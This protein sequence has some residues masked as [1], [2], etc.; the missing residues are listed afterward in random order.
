MRDIH[1]YC[2][3]NERAV[4]AARTCDDAKTGFGTAKTKDFRAEKAFDVARAG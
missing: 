1:L 3:F 2:D 4:L